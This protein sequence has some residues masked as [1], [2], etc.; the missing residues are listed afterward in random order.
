MTDAS[1]YSTADE[2][3]VFAFEGQVYRLTAEQ[4]LRAWQD[5]ITACITEDIDFGR[6]SPAVRDQLCTLL[7]DWP[8]ELVYT[9]LDCIDRGPSQAVLSIG[10]ALLET[11]TS[12]GIAVHVLSWGVR[13]HE[14]LLA[15]SKTSPS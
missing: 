8:K 14:H 15:M 2:V 11:Q 1:T 12:N 6:T 3:A 13:A 9:L 4:C 7:G 5:V 10:A